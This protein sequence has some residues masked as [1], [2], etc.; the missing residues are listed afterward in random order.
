MMF[1]HR[2][3]PLERFAAF[4]LE[5]VLPAEPIALKHPDATGGV[6]DQEGF[7]TIVTPA[8]KQGNSLN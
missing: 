5:T 6:T 3:S 7:P 1:S 4:D 8:A 2:R